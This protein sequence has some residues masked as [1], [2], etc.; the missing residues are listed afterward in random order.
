MAGCLS[1]G[2]SSSCLWSVGKPQH[3]YQLS[4]LEEASSCLN[5]GG[6]GTATSKHG[7]A[8][9]KQNAH[10]REQKEE[11]AFIFLILRNMSLDPT[12][13]CL[14]F[15]FDQV[16]RFT[17]SLHCLCTLYHNSTLQYYQY[18]SCNIDRGQVRQTQFEF[19][20]LRNT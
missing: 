16:Q 11:M 6:G 14:T 13:V 17:D 18:T 1:R 15:Y 12:C 3:K 7:A 20:G 19:K 2:K 10:L 8:M 4:L 5:N 9:G